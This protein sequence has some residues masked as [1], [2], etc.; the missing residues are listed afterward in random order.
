MEAF[1]IEGSQS[2]FS[3]H[4]LSSRRPRDD[5]PSPLRPNFTN[6]ISSLQAKQ[7]SLKLR[8]VL[9][10]LLVTLPLRFKMNLSMKEKEEE[11]LR[12]L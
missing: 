12:Q 1:R 7:L 10:M 4:P 8:S 9:L 2:T 11:D 6:H 5:D 3:P